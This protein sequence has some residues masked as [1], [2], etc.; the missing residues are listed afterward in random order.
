MTYY[1][2]IADEEAKIQR[3][4]AKKFANALAIY[5]DAKTAYHRGAIT[6]EQLR[7]IAE[8]LDL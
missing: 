6:I 4:K 2:F 5:D 1:D 8:E 7:H 3:K